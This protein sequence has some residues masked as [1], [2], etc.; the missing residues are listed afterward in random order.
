MLRIAPFKMSAPS[1]ARRRT[2]SAVR[3]VP[4]GRDVAAAWR[5]A[6]AGLLMALCLAVPQARA[7][8]PQAGS[9]PV[10]RTALGPLQGVWM[11]EGGVAAFLGVPFAQPPVGA[12]RF[13]K[14]PAATAWAPQTLQATRFKPACMQQG[15]VPAEI[16]MAEDCLYLNLY[17]PQATQARPSRG[18]RPVMVFVH[19]GRYW[20]GRA[21]ENAV[22]KLAREADAIVVTVAYRL[23]AFGFLA[24]AERARSGD[25]NLGLQDQQL[26]LAWLQR[27][28]GNFGGDPQ[29]VTLFGE[30]AGAGSTLLQL[31]D[32]A[33]AGLFQRAI[34]QSTWQWR[35]P[36]LA[37]A[38]AGTQA[39]AQRLNC[40]AAPSAAMLACLRQLPAEK[41]TPALADSHAFQPV[42]DGHH[43][44][45]QPLAL[46]EAGRFHRQ[47]P[48]L[49]GLN[50]DEGHFMAMSRTGWKRPDQPV[51]DAVYL[52][53]AREALGPFYAPEQVEDILSWYAPRRAAQGNWQAL[54]ALLGDFY[55]N[56]GSYAGAQAL[57]DRSRRPVQAYWFTHVSRNHTKPFLGAAHG[58]ELDLLFALPVYPPGYALTPEDQALSR[59]MMQAWGQFA[60]TGRA[61]ASPGT[62]PWPAFTAAAPQAQVWSEPGPADAALHR[63]ADAS[64][65]CARWQV[66]LH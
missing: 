2:P 54:S 26:A 30:S 48:V 58:D 9:A 57:A 65:T 25:T 40:P 59:R 56:C 3:A 20:T 44:Q 27:H 37:Q 24:D 66:L 50:R 63:F 28:I 61:S 51:D 15:K 39:L 19:G 47:V 12:L 7:A 5:Q 21:S 18:A 4:A 43:L 49:I 22:Q 36:T 38:T 60:R 42:V 62:V 52:R 64:G 55:L 31:L 14:T 17:V 53:A 23:N 1:A 10:V 8:A 41:I 46:L 6:C 35:L 45:A 33:A 16:G 13:G 29:R 34:L 32:P 11:E